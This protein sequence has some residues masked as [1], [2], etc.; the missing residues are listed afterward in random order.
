MIRIDVEDYCHECLDFSPSMTRASRIFS[1]NME[2]TM[3]DTIVQ[4]EHRKRCAN[5]QRFLENRM[6]VEAVG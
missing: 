3:T 5:I 2:V 4:C 1:D 6:K